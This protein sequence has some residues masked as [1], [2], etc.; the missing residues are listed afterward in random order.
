MSVHVPRTLREFRKWS[1]EMVVDEYDRQIKS[2]HSLS[3]NLLLNELDRRSYE[4][5]ATESHELAVRSHELASES[6][7]LAERSRKLA[8]ASLWLAGASTFLA[9][10]AAAAA[11]IALFLV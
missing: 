3:V 11:V 7:A 9:L 2:L 1:D 5:N 8:V 6:H 10:V 4:R